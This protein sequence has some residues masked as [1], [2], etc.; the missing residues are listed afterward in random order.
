MCCLSGQSTDAA[1]V[2]PGDDGIRHA[3]Q[4][5]AHADRLPRHDKHYELLRVL[6]RGTRML[7]FV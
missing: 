2:V 1:G 5:G 4:V 3:D 6:E 7:N